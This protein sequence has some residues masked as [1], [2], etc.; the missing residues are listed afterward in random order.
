MSYLCLCL[1]CFPSFACAFFSAPH[2]SRLSSMALT[3]P[4][5]AQGALSNMVF[6]PPGAAVVEF[7]RFAPQQAPGGRR[8]PVRVCYM[9]LAHMLGLRYVHVEP[10]GSTFSYTD[11][12]MRVK[13]MAVVR[14]LEA[15][16]L[17]GASLIKTRRIT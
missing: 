17:A 5:L 14:A 12:C 16:S 11:G 6:L 15:L 9:G 8:A 4:F 2:L 13:P 3:P 1:L 10:Q 7:I